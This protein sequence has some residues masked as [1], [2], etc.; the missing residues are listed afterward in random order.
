M[1]IEEEIDGTLI[2]NEIALELELLVLLTLEDDPEH[3]LIQ[4]MQCQLAGFIE[5]PCSN[6]VLQESWCDWPDL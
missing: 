3:P 6:G 1:E 2:E 5:E 4:V